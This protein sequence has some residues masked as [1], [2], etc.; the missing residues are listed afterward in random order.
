MEML[1]ADSQHQYRL[2]SQSALAHL[3]VDIL[4]LLLYGQGHTLGAAIRK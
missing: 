3:V 2:K 1:T 4:V